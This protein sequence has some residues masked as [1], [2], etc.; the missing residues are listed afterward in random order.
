MKKNYQEL[1]IQVVD[2]TTKDVLTSSY[3]YDADDPYW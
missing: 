2:F 1:E 3:D